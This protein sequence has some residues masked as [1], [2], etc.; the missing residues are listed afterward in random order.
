[1]KF[2]NM[3]RLIFALFVLAAAVSARAGAG[4][5]PVSLDWELLETE[6][7]GTYNNMF[8]L[9][10]VSDSDLGADWSIYF[11]M[12]PRTI[13]TADDCPVVFSEVQTGYF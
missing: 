3:K 11:N 6:M 8:V 4:V 13:I 5:A 1:M 7:A 10:N 12:F 2:E 9:K